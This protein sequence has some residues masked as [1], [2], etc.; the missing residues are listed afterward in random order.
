MDFRTIIEIPKP[1]S[2]ITYDSH[3][4]FIGSC[5]AENIGN[6]LAETKISTCVN[7]TGILYNPLSIQRSIHKA[8][9]GKLYDETD[10]FLA[11]GQWNCYD[12]HSRFSCNDKNKCIENL[13]FASAL[14]KKQIEAASIIFVTFGTS[15]VYELAETSEI[16]CNCHKQPEKT[17]H[18][19]LLHSSE[20]VECWKECI[21]E[22]KSI[23][24]NVKLV[25]TVSPIRHWRDGAHQNQVSKANLHIAI[26]ELNETFP[27]TAY[28]PAYE[29]MMDEL[30]DYRFYAD[31]MVHPSKVAV[32]YIWERFAETYF[33]QETLNTMPRILKIVDAANHRPFNP[34]SNEYKAFCRKNLAE[35][36]TIGSQFPNIDFRK[37]KEVFEKVI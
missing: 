14:L 7:P 31:D 35:I 13:N 4:L 16:V 33:T 26:N 21:A 9:S 3:C 25:F 1:N 28:F 10:I 29:I 30:R 23:N 2:K 20:I 34:Q 17:F 6:K 27:E 22:I 11:N 15:F 12:F 5:F 8:I 18:R 37:E 24:S 32:D 36:E 19:R